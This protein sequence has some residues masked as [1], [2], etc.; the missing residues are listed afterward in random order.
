MLLP[1]IP[2]LQCF[3]VGELDVGTDPERGLLLVESG[4]KAGVFVL[5]AVIPGDEF[6]VAHLSWRCLL[7]S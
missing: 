1:A 7:N 5:L 4:V 3:V 2:S 6:I